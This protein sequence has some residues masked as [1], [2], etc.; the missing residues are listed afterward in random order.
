V[1]RRFELDIDPASH[2]AHSDADSSDAH[3]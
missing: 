2:D 1:R 3:E